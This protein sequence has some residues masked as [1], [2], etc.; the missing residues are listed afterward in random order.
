MEPFY[1]S[2]DGRS[3][4]GG[5]GLGL[6]IARGILEAHRGELRIED[7]PGGG[8]TFVLTLPRSPEGDTLRPEKPPC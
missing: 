7:T 8:A 5:V 4:K 3:Q 6:A 2:R 1:Q